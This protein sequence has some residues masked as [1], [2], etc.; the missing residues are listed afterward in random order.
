MSLVAKRFETCADAILFMDNLAYGHDDYVFRGHSKEHYKL[1]TTLRRHTSI[2]HE[3]WSSDVDDLIDSFRTG[4]AKLNILP[5]ESENRL[6]WLEYARHHG[7]PTPALDF[8]YS[9]YVAL[10]F[11]FNGV[12]KSFNAEE[13]EYVVIYAISPPKLAHRWATISSEYDHNE[14][15]SFLN[16]VEGLF[17][18]GFPGPH[19]Q[20][21][22]APG[23]FNYRMHRQQ[24]CL[25]YD[26]LNYDHLSVKDLDDLI[27]SFEE[28]DLQHGNGEIQKSLPTGYRI[29]INSSCVS[30][31][32]SRLELM[33]INAGSLYMSA[34]GVAEDVKNTYNYN[35]K[36]GYLRGVRFPNPSID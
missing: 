28:P 10:F 19:L 33:G 16:P 27:A 29:L 17:A 30:E 9:P 25:L 23:K 26:T 18:K 11:S 14:W 22:P 24:G 7:V 1:T 2:P 5:F 36:T 4:L 34:D 32:F 6:D 20:F 31:V 8:S 13:K 21:I 3:S 12:R 35:T 15:E